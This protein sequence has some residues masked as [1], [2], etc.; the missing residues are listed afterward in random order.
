[1]KYFKVNIK[2][3]RTT[4]VTFSSAFIAN[5]EQILHT[6]LVFPLLSLNK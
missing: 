2:D 5:F 3:N 6:V 1:M 4:S